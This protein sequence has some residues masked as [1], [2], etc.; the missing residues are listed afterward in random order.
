MPIVA[1]IL[2]LMNEKEADSDYA[3]PGEA[4]V[5]ISDAR[6]FHEAD[7]VSFAPLDSRD[8][9]GSVEAVSFSG[10]LGEISAR[11]YRPLNAANPA[12]LVWF[13]GGG[14]VT[15]SLDTAD[16][17]VRALCAR[18]G[19][20]VLSVDYALAPEQFWPAAVHDARA[21]LLWAA[22]HRD[23]LGGEGS[24]L[25]GGDSAGGN[26]AAVLAN[27]ET[28]VVEG[29]VLLYPVVD[30]DIATT[31]YPSRVTNGVGCFV[32]WADIEWAIREYAPD[33]TRAGDPLLSPIRAANFA[34]VAPAIIAAAEYDPLRD[35][36]RAYAKA[37]EL[38]GVEVNY[39]EFAGLVHGGFDMMQPVPAVNVAMSDIAE[40]LRVLV[41]QL[42][43]EHSG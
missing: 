19:I 34:G 10:P 18:A 37:L 31:A 6:R 3:R 36:N 41:A 22:S 8:A 20:A 21:A 14:W 32:A 1:E 28:D 38:H 35:E 17:V 9:V 39:F 33:F 13:H 30:L 23:Q 15:G 7:I 12:T 4:P 43:D 16:A 2:S 40:A 24:I 25:V 42:G 27:T 29:Q 11:L 26:L 5:S